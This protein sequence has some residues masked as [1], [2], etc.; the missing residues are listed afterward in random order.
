MSPEN[1]AAKMT[2]ARAMQATRAVCFHALRCPQKRIYSRR[3]DRTLADRSTDY[4]VSLTVQKQD[5]FTQ[6]RSLFFVFVF[7]FFHPPVDGEK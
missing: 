1:M 4:E 7:V 2:F 3:N 6:K 5:E